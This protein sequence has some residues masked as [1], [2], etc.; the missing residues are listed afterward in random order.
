MPKG[1]ALKT[2]N[3]PFLISYVSP[4]HI[5]Y[6]TEGQVPACRTGW[7]LAFYVHESLC[8]LHMLVSS[9]KA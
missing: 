9:V 5:F 1:D 4:E 7:E 8:K 2:F 3:T 6:D